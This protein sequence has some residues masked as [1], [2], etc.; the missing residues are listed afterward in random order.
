MSRRTRT[1]VKEYLGQIKALEIK[2]RQKKEQ[3]EHMKTMAQ[4]GGAIRYDKD[5]VVTSVNADKMADDVAR[6]VDLEQEIKADI[7]AYEELKNEI[8][9]QIHRLKDQ[10][11]IDVLYKRFVQHK[12]LFRIADEIHYSPE[13]TK[14][15]TANALDAFYEEVLK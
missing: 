10:R 3:L 4:A 9:N 14:K 2:I 13:Y 12:V 8:I 5:S 11:H 15:I 1:R 7:L 6:Y